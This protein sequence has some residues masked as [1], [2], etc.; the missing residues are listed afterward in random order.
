M[1]PEPPTPPH[2]SGPVQGV[3]VQRLGDIIFQ[4]RLLYVLGF[5]RMR[6]GDIRAGVET[7]WRIDAL[8]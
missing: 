1:P 3:P 6:G 2:P 7:L 5:A 4:S 8:G